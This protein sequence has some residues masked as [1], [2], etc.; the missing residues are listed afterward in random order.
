MSDLIDRLNDH[1]A[2]LMAANEWV[3]FARPLLIEHCRLEN[4]LLTSAIIEA[5]RN[6]EGRKLSDYTE[7]RS[8][9]TTA[10]RELERLILSIRNDFM[11][12]AT[13]F[14]TVGASEEEEDAYEALLAALKEG[15]TSFDAAL[16]GVADEI[17]PDKSVAEAY[18]RGY[19]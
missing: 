10:Q 11:A 9:L 1:A 8:I 2:A 5:R 14:L 7:G 3:A 15:V 12:D 6:G 17:Q 19:L 18:R 16:D 4:H 13:P